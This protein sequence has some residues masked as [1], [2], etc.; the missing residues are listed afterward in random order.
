[1]RILFCNKYNFEFSGTEVYLFD[2]MRRLTAFGHEVALFSM[3]DARGEPTHFDKHFVPQIDF[4]RTGQSALV[5]IKNAAHVIY[6]IGARKRLRSMVAEFRPDVAHVRN[7]YHHLSPS[8]LWELRAQSVPVL[9]HLN[10]FKMLCPNYNFVAHGQA[11]EKC[12]SGRF[13]NVVTEGCHSHSPAAGLVLAVEAYSHRAARTYEKCVDRF[14]APSRFVKDKLVEHGYRR[15]WIDVLPHFQGLPSFFP[16]VKSDAP[17]LYFG[18]LSPEKGVE[19]LLRAA[20][21]L[22]QVPF[23][24][25]GEGPQR[26]ALEAAGKKLKLRNVEFVGHVSGDA[27]ERLLSASRFTVLP[28]HAYET[29]GKSILESYAWGRPVVA[30]DLGSRRELVHEGETGVLYRP[31]DSAQL[32]AAISFLDRRPRLVAEMGAAGR[33]LVRSYHDPENHCRA[34][35]KIYEGLNPRP[36]R[37][38]QFPHPN[39]SSAVPEKPLKIAFIGG[40]GV[41]SKYS[42]I[43]SYYEEVGSLLASKGHELTVYC[44]NH[45]TP[46]I[47]EHRRMKVV[48]L[49]SIRSKHLDT[50]TH[51]FLSTLHVMFSDCDI[52]NYHALGSAAFSLLPRLVGKKTV[53]TVQGLDWQRKK[54]NWFASSILRLGERASG[55]LPDKTILVSKTLHQHY[56]QDYPGKAVYIPNGATIRRRARISR[57]PEWGLSPDNYI[58]FM[59]R[60]SPEKNCHLL[61]EAFERIKTPVKLVL[62]G[63]SSHSRGYVERLHKHRSDRVIFLDW[64]SGEPLD[65]LLTNAMLFVLPSDMEGLSLALLDAMGAE[66][67][68]LASDIPE[69]VEV[70]HDAG[71]TFRKGDVDD[72]EKALRSLLWNPMLREHARRQA[73]ARVTDQYL[74]PKI[75]DQVEAMYFALMHREVTRDSVQVQMPA[76]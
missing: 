20:Q 1:M 29:L 40:R 33:E 14:L 38:A 13:W 73:L 16:P 8:I 68:V 32:A 6:S 36:A 74:W 4:K 3:A 59:G 54:W 21:R 61:I 71:F 47:A 26:A 72:L 49:P 5:Q 46:V 9:Y 37:V 62:A 7:I 56:R 75:A 2:L 42:G 23:Q 18:R 69:N 57:L 53:V 30:S 64:V 51:T 12:A 41:I 11:C 52:V 50:L 19:D 70:V 60:L 15:Q 48:R 76:A 45:F 24:I 63:G 28:S 66:V 39:T 17:V 31:G 22:P 27:L 44:R 34:L 58:L 35:T 10:D 67:C 55:M 43:E 65:E 25:A